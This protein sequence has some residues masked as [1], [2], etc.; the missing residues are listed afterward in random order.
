MDGF[1]DKNGTMVLVSKSM[2]GSKTWVGKKVFE[3]NDGY[4]R[5]K[6]LRV[7]FLVTWGVGGR[8]SLPLKAHPKVL[9]K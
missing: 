9:P 2:F 4:L 3:N 6:T 7:L 5:M 1:Y 8:I